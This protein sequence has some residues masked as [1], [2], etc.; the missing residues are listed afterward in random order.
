MEVYG[1]KPKRFTSA[2]FEYVW[3]YY[4]IHIIVTLLVIIAVVY[5]WIAIASATKYDFYLCIAGDKYITDENKEDLKEVLKD[6]ITDINGDGEINIEILDYSTSSEIKDIEFENAMKTK[7]ELE[8]QAGDSFLYIVSKKVADDLVAN[9]AA[10]DFFEKP[11]N[12]SGKESDNK[13]FARAEES[14]VLKDAGIQ[15]NDLYVGV[16]EFTYSEGDEEDVA[17]RNNAIEVAKYILGN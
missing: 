17:K 4:K 9:P 6:K 7:L 11:E 5:T 12:L 1:E 8:L 14:V 3:E 13:Y 16:R 15:Y 10:N 2:W